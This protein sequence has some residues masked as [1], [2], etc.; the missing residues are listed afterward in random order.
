MAS[1]RRKRSLDWNYKVLHNSGER[2]LITRDSS[3]KGAMDGGNGDGNLESK[4]S[5]AAE[6]NQM[7]MDFLINNE[8]ELFEEIDVFFDENKVAEALSIEEID[9][10][11]AEVKELRR[12]FKRAHRELKSKLN[13][14]DVQYK[15]RN[16]ERCDAITRYIMEA[17]EEK[18]RRVDNRDQQRVKQEIK[19]KE[20]QE[21]EKE[22]VQREKGLQE[23][24]ISE[25]KTKEIGEKI[26]HIKTL[27]KAAETV[28]DDEVLELK[29][30]LADLDKELRDLRDMRDKFETFI[31][32]FIDKEA[33]IEKLAKEYKTINESVVAHKETLKN[34]IKKR[35]LEDYKLKAISKLNID[36]PK[37]SGTDHK[38]DIQGVPKR[39][40]PS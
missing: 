10:N 12:G 7:S 1:G 37:F 25:I 24:R 15:G 22:A 33:I 38:I 30:N 35:E 26:V 27:C 8:E 14:Y 9:Q 3:T 34:E 13:D 2:I 40:E 32:E 29:N 20:T 39:F 19:V 36:I 6:M 4:V 17:K 28:E 31:S 16:E 18:R 11:L 23:K 21:A 5:V